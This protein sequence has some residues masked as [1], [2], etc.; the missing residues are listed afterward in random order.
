MEWE[1]LDSDFSSSV[2]LVG[3]KLIIQPYR[4]DIDAGY[5]TCIA[6]N[7][8]VMSN[9]TIYLGNQHSIEEFSRNIQIKIIKIPI[10]IDQEKVIEL[11]CNPGNIHCCL[12][13]EVTV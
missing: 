13:K 12:K 11:S 5:Y 3:N 8:D 2:R 4:P 10:G 6:Y 9:S 7:D 1:R